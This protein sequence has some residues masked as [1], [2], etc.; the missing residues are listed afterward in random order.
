[1]KRSI[2][3]LTM[4]LMLSMAFIGCDMNGSPE[5]PELSAPSAGDARFLADDWRLLGPTFWNQDTGDGITY[6]IGGT[7][8]V[9]VDG[10][11]TSYPTYTADPSAG[12]FTLDYGT[13]F[14][15]EGEYVLSMDLSSGV[16]T[17][18][19]TM[20]IPDPFVA[21]LSRDLY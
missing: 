17:L 15:I 6:H 11:L 10:V 5:V 1:M 16:Q 9:Y 18:T 4:V 19:T 2:F 13:G 12:T 14:V 21:T 3:L 20:Y 8:D 7:A